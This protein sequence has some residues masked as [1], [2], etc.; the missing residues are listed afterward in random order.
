MKIDFVKHTESIS[1]GVSD[2]SGNLNDLLDLLEILKFKAKSKSKLE[3]A[4]GIGQFGTQT[5]L[6]PFSH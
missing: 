1:N 4:F 3:F 5:N 6:S 2:S